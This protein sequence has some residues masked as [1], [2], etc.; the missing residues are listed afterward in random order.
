MEVAA[1]MD[2]G[3]NAGTDFMVYWFIGRGGWQY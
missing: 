1:W 2:K 3:M